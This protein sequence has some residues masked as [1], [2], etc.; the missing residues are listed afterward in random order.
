MHIGID[1][2]SSVP[3]LVVLKG[4]RFTLKRYGRIGYSP[5]LHNNLQGIM[6][7]N[8]D[9]TY[10]SMPAENWL[11]VLILNGEKDYFLKL[12]RKFSPDLL[13]SSK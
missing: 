9:Y 2:L 10:P 7:H 3:G 4:R 5:C 6:N 12:G 8:E 11:K 1:A 13:N